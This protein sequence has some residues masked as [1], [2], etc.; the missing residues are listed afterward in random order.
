MTKKVKKYQ[1]LSAQDDIL[2]LQWTVKKQKFS[3]ETIRGVLLCPKEVQNLYLRNQ[4]L[5]YFTWKKG[6][7]LVG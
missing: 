4:K 7:H 1:K 3:L 5:F 2:P 6:N